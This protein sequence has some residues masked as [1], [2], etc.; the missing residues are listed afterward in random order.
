MSI[1]DRLLTGVNYLQGNEALVEGAIVAG[2]R[3]SAGYPI[4][5]ATEILERMAWRMPM[6]GGIAVQGEDEIASLGMVIGASRTGYKAMTATSGPGLSLMSEGISYACMTETPCVIVDVQRCGPSTGIPTM[7]S[8]GDMMQS[9]WGCHGDHEIIALAPAS[10][11]EMFDLVV[12]AFNLA[13]TYRVPTFIMAEETVAHMR[14]RV[15][16]RESLCLVRRNMPRSDIVSSRTKNDVMND[17]DVPPML[18]FGQGF[19]VNVTGLSH[20][21]NAYPTIQGEEHVKLVT[22]LCDKIRKNVDI[23]V[24]TE[25]KFIDDAEIVVISYGI[26]ARAALKAVKDARKEGIRAG[27]LRL[28]TVWPFPE[29]I[30]EQVSRK[31]DT[32]IVAE[33]NLGQIFYEVQRSAS[34]RT[35]VVLAPKPGIE[36]HTPTEI[37]EVIKRE[38]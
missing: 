31:V 27:Y 22:R 5:P 29:K 4:S 33:M 26:P 34:R 15:T 11:Q 30:I 23:I 13:E 12:D 18:P 16:I 10:V 24:R 35:N 2:C 19:R 20:D 3:F 14:D 17:V 37:L 21:E 25:E 28:I 1:S 8:Q 7:S 6:V 9:K 38:T 36:P 32:I